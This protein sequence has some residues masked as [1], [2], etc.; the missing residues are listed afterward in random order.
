M[1]T[2]FFFFSL[3]GL[4]FF[5]TVIFSIPVFA[6]PEKGVCTCTGT[7]SAGE[8]FT[9]VDFDKMCKELANKGCDP[10]GS[11]TAI[12][13][14]KA[15]PSAEAD[16]TKSGSNP[17]GFMKKLISDTDTQKKVQVSDYA[18]IF[19]G[20]SAKPGRYGLTDPL[21][22]VSIPQ[23]IGG[24]VRFAMGLLGALF[25][26]MFVYGGI[27]WMVSA[28][29]PKKIATAQ[30]TLVYAFA[31]LVVVGLAYFAITF[32]FAFGTQVAGGG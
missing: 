1:S 5:G 12:C 11:G 18:C 15:S 9:A 22:G 7:L 2:R 20:S 4:A 17:T 14:P 32:I 8:G 30:K 29:E 10:C 3:I 28:G 24:V 6:A 21:N 16:C 26:V 13:T 25:V 31:G 27:L 23:L 19:G